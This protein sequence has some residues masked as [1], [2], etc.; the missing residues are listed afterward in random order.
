VTLSKLANP[1]LFY[2][3]S[4]ENAQKNFEKLK[5]TNKRYVC[6]KKL[7]RVSSTLDRGDER[8]MEREDGRVRKVEGKRRTWITKEKRL[9]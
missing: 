5:S 8:L 6:H 3:N 9:S 7:V 4:P 1:K 2:P